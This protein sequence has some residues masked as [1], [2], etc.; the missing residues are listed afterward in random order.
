MFQIMSL[1]YNHVTREQF[2]KDLSEKTA[3]I[4]LFDPSGYL[5]GFS[6]IL[7]TDL[8][9]ENE[10]VVAIYSGDTVLDRDYW[11]NG[12]M[13]M[14]FSKYILKVKRQNLFRP[15]YWFLISKGY[16]TY[17]L[18]ANNFGTHFPRYEMK[19]PEREQKLM[20]SFYSSKF[21]SLYHSE[22]DL[23]TPQGESCALKISVADI[24]ESLLKHPRISFFAQ[25]NPNWQKGQELTCVAKVTLWIPIHY[26]SKRAKKLVLNFFSPKT[27]SPD[28]V[29]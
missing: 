7:V 8:T 2:H 16:K 29:R 18:M 9:V 17:L 24:D 19:T 28:Y 21:G 5:C 26:F 3:V 4:M 10:K 11:G 1:Y 25:K 13:G 14:A 23:I 12:A 6:T 22:S 15:V 27:A 20:Q